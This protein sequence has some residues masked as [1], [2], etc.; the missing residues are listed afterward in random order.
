MLTQKQREVIALRDDKGLTFAEIA[1]R[2]G[3]NKSAVHKSY[4]AGKDK[5]AEKKARLDPGVHKVLDKLG[6]GDLAG[7]HSGWVHKENEKTGEWVSTYYYLGKDGA[8]S[9][10]DLEDVL[11]SAVEA[12]FTGNLAKRARPAPSGENLLVIDL[13]DLHIGKLCVA[14]ETGFTYDRDEAVR[15]G[16]EGTRRLLECAQAH[17]V[18]HILFVLGNDVIHIDRPDKRTTAGTPQDTDGTLAVMWDDAFAFYVACIDMCREVA[19]VS[20]LYC[21]SNHDWMSGYFLARAIRAWYRD[22]P[23]VSATDYNT[24]L[25][26]RK[27]FQFENNGFG[28]THLDGAKEADLP[29]LMVDEARPMVAGADHLYWIGHHLHHKVRKKGTGSQRRQTEKDLIG[30]TM[31]TKHAGDRSTLAPQLEV[32]RSPS[33][34]DGWH[35]RNGYINRQAAECFLHD[36]HDGQFGRYTAWF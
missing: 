34:P 20:L 21:P 36:P 14:S 29:Q 13:A 18:A 7:Q 12:V 4:H 26:H 24:S 6:M 10:A 3:R 28:F 1:E 32:V 15:R 30:M 11:S 17:G 22:C 31:I 23:E 2:T 35:D 9:E 27:Y 19:P 16:L 25:R 8:P 5:L 33:P